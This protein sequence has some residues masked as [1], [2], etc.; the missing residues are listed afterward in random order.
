MTTSAKKSLDPQQQQ[1][2]AVYAKSLLAAARESGDLERVVEELESFGTE[3]LVQQPRFLEVM[4]STRIGQ[5]E[6]LQLIDRVFQNNASPTLVNFLKVISR[7]GRFECIGAIVH[8]VRRL[9]NEEIGIVEA[10]VTAASELEESV[11]QQIAEKLATILG[12]K[13][14]LSL[15]VDPS[16]LG[17]LKIRVGDK[18]FDGSVQSQLERVRRTTFE[19]SAETIRAQFDRFAQ[20]Q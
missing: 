5:N 17:G 16:M 19:K 18:V 9:Y 15:S 11:Q 4:E 13:V 8:E 7:K 2:G 12:K 3:V 14:N 20:A 10:Q 6:K 1:I